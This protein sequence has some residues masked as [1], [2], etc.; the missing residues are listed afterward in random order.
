MHCCIA[1]IL[2]HQSDIKF[3]QI[4]MQSQKDQILFACLSC[5]QGSK[6]IST[7]YYLIMTC[8]CNYKEDKYLT[9]ARNY[10]LTTKT[11]K[12]YYPSKH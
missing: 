4:L 7:F 3:E 6:H 12:S 5:T 2:T 11:I 1:Y 8:I 10:I 9:G